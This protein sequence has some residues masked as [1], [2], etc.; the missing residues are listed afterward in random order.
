[1]LA[2]FVSLLWLLLAALT[3]LWIAYDMARDLL[4]TPPKRPAGRLKE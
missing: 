1:M 2:L 3:C 4:R